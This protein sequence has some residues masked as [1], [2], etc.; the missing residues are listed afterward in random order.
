MESKENISIELKKYFQC[1]K[2]TLVEMMIKRKQKSEK[3]KWSPALQ[4]DNSKP[5][6]HYPKY[7]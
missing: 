1:Y 3:K 2:K 6:I 4:D 5:Y 7:S